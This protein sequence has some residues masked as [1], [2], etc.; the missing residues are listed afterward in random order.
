[1][2]ESTKT[3]IYRK[4]RNSIMKI[5]NLIKHKKRQSQTPIYKEVRDEEKKNNKEIKDSKILSKAYKKVMNVISNF[6]GDMNNVNNPSPHYDPTIEKRRQKID[7]SPIN[8]QSPNF[9]KT[10]LPKVV[11][12]N[13]TNN[14]RRLFAQ[15]HSSDKR[16]SKSKKDVLC[17]NYKNLLD[18]DLKKLSKKRV[19]R[20][21]AFKV[22][23]MRRYSKKLLPSASEKLFFFKPKNKLKHKYG[24]RRSLIMP[25]QR[26]KNINDKSLSEKKLGAENILSNL[27][28]SVSNINNRTKIVARKNNNDFT[29]PFHSIQQKLSIIIDTECIQKKLYE[30]ENNEITTQIN[31][32]PGD[33]GQE[34]FVKR[35]ALVFKTNMK[36]LS[37]NP[38]KNNFLKIMKQYNKE[39][40]FRCLMQKDCV[41]D[42]LD[43]EEVFEN[44]IVHSFY[45]KPDSIFL[46]ILDSIIFV[47]SLIILFYLPIYLSRKLFFCKE[48][49]NANSFIFYTI[50]IFYIIDFFINFFKSYYNF[51]EVLIT[52]KK[53]IFIHYI[54]KWFLLD[55]ISAF[56][57]YIIFALKESECIGENIYYDSKLNNSGKHSFNYNTNPYNMHYLLMLIKAIKTL[58]TFKKNIAVDKIGEILYDHE[59]FNQWIEIYL[60]AFFFFAF[61]N[62][63]SCFYIFLGRNTLDS[64]IF[65]D[66]KEISSFAEIYL[67]SIYYLVVTVT[68][69]GY[70]DLIGNTTNEI[71]FQII[72]LIAGTCVYTWLISSVSTYVQKSNEKHIKYEGKIQILEEIKLNNPHFSEE[73]YLKI[74]KLLYYR[75]FHEEETEKNI[76]LDSLPNSLKNN[77]IIEMY[78][79][80]INGFKFFHDIENRDFIV[81]VISKLE[82]I[83]GFKGDILVE[84]GESLEDIIFIRNGILSLEIWLDMIHPKKS[85]RNYL[86]KNGFIKSKNKRRFG[87]FNLPFIKYSN[88]NI[89]VSEENIKRLKILDIKKNEHFG[90]VFI[91]LNKKS[92]LWVRVKSSKADLLL[93]KKMD[94][95]DISS[96]YQDIWKQIIKKPLENSKIINRLT[97]KI[98]SHFCNFHGIKS[99]LFKKRNNYKYYPKYYLKPYLNK[100]PFKNHGKKK[101]VKN[102]DIDIDI[103]RSKETKG[104]ISTNEIYTDKGFNNKINEEISENRME[105]FDCSLK[106]SNDISKNN[107]VNVIVESNKDN[108]DNHLTIENDLKSINSLSYKD[109]QS[110][111]NLID[112]KEKKNKSKNYLYSF[113]NKDN[114]SFL[115]KN[116]I[117]PGLFKKNKN[118]KNIKSIKTNTEEEMLIKESIDLKEVNNNKFKNIAEKELYKKFNPEEINDEIYPGEN[119]PIFLYDNGNPNGKKNYSKNQKILKDNIYINNLNIIGTNYLGGNAIEQKLK[120]FHNLEISGESCVEIASIYENINQITNYQYMRDQKLKEETKAFLINK[121]KKE[122]KDYKEMFTLSPRK[123]RIVH[124]PSMDN[125]NFMKNRLA[126]LKEKSIELDYINNFNKSINQNKSNEKMVKKLKNQI[127]LGPNCFAS[128]SKKE[129]KEKSE[130]KEENEENEEKEI[131]ENV[132]KIKYTKTLE[133]KGTLKKKKKNLELRIIS[134]NLKKSSQNLNQPDIFYAGLFTQLISKGD[135]GKNE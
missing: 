125:K 80:Y 96:N 45:F 99:K 129:I 135:P 115:K 12:S 92:P 69:V 85:I 20:W 90:D 43:D 83:I 21:S 79:T 94:A 27:S 124:S 131:K 118:N 15:K 62:F 117:V 10:E 109:E 104:D 39:K 130:E 34:H 114:E 127:S 36:Q 77:L 29:N 35:N 50:D 60:Y 54:K 105:S 75:K 25:S 88:N 32:L 18:E 82:P 93:L 6:I 14:Y 95:Y 49:I 87:H 24:F 56:P 22:Y 5:D 65:R 1:M 71:I 57:F 128:K 33:I 98:L 112:S 41:Y 72:M 58:K 120:N 76:V 134:D 133:T 89:T 47:F 91:F 121:C 26:K 67:A 102:M 44:Q 66:G 31:N 51:D 100:N 9:S 19:K 46:Y 116:N 86:M 113:K 103:D 61:L 59:Y 42:S 106:K 64:W 84:E 126:K 7:F 37:M 70:G 11:K 81:Q 3:N 63:C 8:R 108:K 48:D 122:K 101:K 4:S 17:G 28:S 110:M 38:F 53:R 55:F 40:N 119:S 30:Y 111:K 68:T 13:K 23:S 107:T 52:D 123:K 97:C 78:K 132:T 2:K 74:L 16:L 73:L